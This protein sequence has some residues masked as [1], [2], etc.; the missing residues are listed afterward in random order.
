MATRLPPPSATAYQHAPP[1][2]SAEGI[3]ASHLASF[4]RLIRVGRLQNS[5]GGVTSWQR[6][7]LKRTRATTWTWHHLARW[8]YGKHF[9]QW[10]SSPPFCFCRAARLLSTWALRHLSVTEYFAKQYTMDMTGCS[11][12]AYYMDYLLFQ[13]YL[14]RHLGVGDSP[15]H[16]RLPLTCAVYY[17]I[18]SDGIPRKTLSTAWN[19]AGDLF[20]V[21]ARL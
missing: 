7:A 3:I 11:E 10:A 6:Y 16:Q 8:H 5:S 12:Q 4:G 15:R 14:S 2:I 20:P 1:E 9:A 21:F 18:P 19:W 13:R 17:P